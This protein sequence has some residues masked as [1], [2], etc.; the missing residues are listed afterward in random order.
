MTI[1]SF[2][3]QHNINYALYSPDFTSR[4][5]VIETVCSLNETSDTAS[6]FL[7]WLESE[8]EWSPT[9]IFP[10]SKYSCMA[11]YPEITEVLFP[12]L[13]F[14]ILGARKSETFYLP[15]FR[16]VED[17]G[18]TSRLV[19][20]PCLLYFGL[21]SSAKYWDSEVT[22]LP[23]VSNYSNKTGLPGWC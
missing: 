6:F 4:A 15:V 19:S 20:G 16:R 17:S 3:T 2:C 8:E 10:Q 5:S 9:L 11:K 21:S 18:A 13:L 1:I 23:F 12:V 7:V 22:F 14:Q